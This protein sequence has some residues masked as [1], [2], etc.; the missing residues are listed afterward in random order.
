MN[1]AKNVARRSQA[2]NER[3]AIW[4]YTP[5]ARRGIGHSWSGTPA[6]RE[7]FRKTKPTG[8]AEACAAPRRTH[9]LA[10]SSRAYRGAAE[11]LSRR[12]YPLRLF[13]SS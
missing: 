10:N 6:G 4:V 3:G 7:P 13:R 9:L 11:Y 8:P 1:P 2:S 12:S 5:L